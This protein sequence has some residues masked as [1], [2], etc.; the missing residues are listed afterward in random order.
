[1][2]TSNHIHKF[3]D[4][5]GR[6][7]QHPLVFVEDFKDDGICKICGVRIDKLFNK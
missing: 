4:T 6:Y 2:K 5:K 3:Q 1:M 7:P